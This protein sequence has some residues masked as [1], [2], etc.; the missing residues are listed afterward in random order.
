MSNYIRLTRPYLMVVT[1]FVLLRFVLELAGLSAAV[2]SEI[3]LTRL[4]VVLAVLLGLR[5]AREGLG[6]FNKMLAANFVYSFWGIFLIMIVTTLD[7]VLGLNT[8][9]AFGP[10]GDVM[11]LGHHLLE[12]IVEIVV[13]TLVLS[14]ISLITAKLSAGPEAA[15]A[16]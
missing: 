13:F 16:A 15:P 5:F 4:V 11:P 7:V 1:I 8:H 10:D 2:T 9:Y 14:I 6:G 12:H 3:S